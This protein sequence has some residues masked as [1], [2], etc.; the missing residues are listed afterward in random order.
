MKSIGIDIG[1]YSIKVVEIQTTSKG[2]QLNQFF[3][4]KLSFVNNADIELQVIEFLRDLLNQYDHSQTKFSMCLRQDKVAVRNKLFPFSDR[5]KIHKSLAFE[6]EEDIPFSVENAIFDA[7]IV[8]TIGTSAEILACAAPKIHIQKALQ[9]AQDI[10]VDLDVLSAEGAAFANTVERW[11]ESPQAL[12]APTLQFDESEKPPRALQVILN[13]GHTRTLVSAFDNGVLVGVRTIP[14]GGK[15]IADA[16]ALKY[17]IPFIEALK[18]LET[19]GFILT[20]K[21]GATFDQVTFSETIAKSVR[22]MIRDLQLS[23]LEIKAEFN[24]HILNVNMTGG[25]SQVQ[26]L[27]AFLTQMLELPVNRFA[28]L[29]HFQNSL[30]DRGTTTEAKIGLA[31]GLAVEAIKKPRNP[32]V[33]F[34]RGEFVKQNYKLQALWQKW[35]YTAKLATAALVVLFVYSNLRESISTGL[36]DRTQEILKTQAKSVAKLSNKNATEGGIKKYIKEN[37]KRAQDLKMLASVANMNSALDVLKKVNDATPAKTAISLEVRRF[38]VAQSQV[39]IEGY[40]NSANEVTLLQQ[41]LAN[42][43]ATGK[44]TSQTPTIS[45]MPNKIAFSF[46]FE[47]DRGIQKVSK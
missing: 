36:V 23:L 10:N 1:S 42:A 8:K 19:K 2:F 32:A 39:F 7:K 4:H 37:K 18:E 28:T 17:E 43:S 26:N 34:L 44:I 41:S 14:W 30:F 45:Q 20:N 21:Q 35:G 16:I 31:L 3:E 25:V 5:I 22:E 24:A 33:N 9:L 6:L 11:Y 46:T 12:P 27:G 15:N 29:E 47:V 40:T 13:L 38:S